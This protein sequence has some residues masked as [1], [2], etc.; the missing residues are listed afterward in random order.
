MT[1]REEAFMSNLAEKIPGFGHLA[2]GSDRAY[3]GFLNKL[4]AD[5]FDDLV[6]KAKLTGSDNPNMA[7]DIAT[8]V[9]AA[10]GRGSLP[11]ALE[12]AAP[13]LNGVFFS[14]RLMASRLTLLNPVYYLN[15]KTD[16]FVRKEALKSLM[17]FAAVG[18]TV[19]G[20]AQAA[21][22]GRAHV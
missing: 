4:R 12:K 5:V 10:T 8:F 3:T 7:K 9:N 6:S 15:P 21:E 17:G 22:I 18:S 14:P 13:A 1:S 20:L 2:R 11:A 16:P 19:L